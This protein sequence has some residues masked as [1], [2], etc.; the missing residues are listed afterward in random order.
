[1]ETYING[2][3]SQGNIVLKLYLVEKSTSC[4]YFLHSSSTGRESAVV[5][6]ANVIKLYSLPN[7]PCSQPDN[8][9]GLSQ[10]T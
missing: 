7:T 1:M 5:A 4:L 3:I 10:P 9:L 8:Y 6:E 2:E